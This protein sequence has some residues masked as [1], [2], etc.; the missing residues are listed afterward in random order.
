MEES[1]HYSVHIIKPVDD[2][3]KN[4]S[5]GKHHPGPLVYGIDISQVWDFD[6]EL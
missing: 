6:F 3:E 5:D 4:E 2:V 1:Q